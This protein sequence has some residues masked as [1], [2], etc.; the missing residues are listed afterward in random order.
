MTS[1]TANDSAGWYELTDHPFGD[2][3]A[4]ISVQLAPALEPAVAGVER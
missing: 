2:G 3:L 4:V 1:E